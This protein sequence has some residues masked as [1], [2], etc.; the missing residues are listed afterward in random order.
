MTTALLGPGGRPLDPDQIPRSPLIGVDGRP[1]L[2]RDG[3]ALLG[4]NTP[5]GIPYPLPTDPVANGAANMQAMATFLDPAEI[6]LYRAENTNVSTGAW[7]T[8]GFT[9]TP[10]TVGTGITPVA[11]GVNVAAAGRYRVE[12]CATFAA[13]SAGTRRGIAVGPPG[14]VTFSTPQD[15]RTPC[16]SDAT[17]VSIATTVL[18]TAPGSI[19]VYLYQNSGATILASAIRFNVYRAP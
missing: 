6:C 14:G 12:A 2:D 1:L 4:A 16:G 18:M 11:G 7:G 8:T 15:I 10:W 3:V 9:S 17:P 5:G 13:N 19:L